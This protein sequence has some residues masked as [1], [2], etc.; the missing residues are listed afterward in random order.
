MKGLLRRTLFNAFA[1]FALSILLGGV[2]IHGGLQTLLFGGLILTFLTIF[3]EPILNLLS[4]PVTFVTMGLFSLITHA[5]LFYVLTVLMPQ[6]E[7][8]AFVFPGTTLGGFVIPRMM[9]NTFFA[10]ILAA[11]LHSV[12]I[13]TLNW[14]LRD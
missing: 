4:L 3:L 14:L 6:I 1:L 12:I 10:Y 2:T 5:I 13:S 11:S 7:V 9:L 8:R